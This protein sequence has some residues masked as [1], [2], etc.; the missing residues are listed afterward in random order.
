MTAA[1][2]H[3]G[4]WATGNSAFALSVLAGLG[5]IW[6]PVLLGLTLALSALIVAVAIIDHRGPWAPARRLRR[7]GLAA[8]VV[9]GWL[10][11]LGLAGTF[12]PLRGPALV[13]AAAACL[14]GSGEQAQ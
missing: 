5:S 13:A 4:R 7:A 14:V 10:L 2:M 12:A 9:G 6:D 11:F 3:T 8:L 1:G